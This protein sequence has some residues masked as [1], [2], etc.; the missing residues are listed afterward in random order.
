MN[1]PT[2]IKKAIAAAHGA[3]VDLV[4]GEKRYVIIPAD[5]YQRL[6]EI[7]AADD[8]DPAEMRRTMAKV[9]EEDWSDPQMD[10]YDTRQ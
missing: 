4:D 10:S 8:W 1:V 2:D 9:M 3:P 5:V 6:K 7:A